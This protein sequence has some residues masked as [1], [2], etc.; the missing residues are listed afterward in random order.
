MTGRV[1]TRPAPG[2]LSR[3]A[4]VR[5]VLRGGASRAG[6]LVA[7]HALARDTA[8]DPSDE[9]GTRLTVVAS[10][11]VGNAVQRNRAKRLLREAARVQAWR[12]GLDVVLVARSACAA[13]GLSE[14]V[15]E[16]RTLGSRLDVLEPD[17]T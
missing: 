4:D 6:R 12:T 5:R 11:R 14:V 10:R 7:V 8:R 16:L 3:S 17:A 15:E 2:R 9:D 1:V 13:S